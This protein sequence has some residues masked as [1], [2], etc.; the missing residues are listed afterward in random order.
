[1]LACGLAL[2]LAATGCDSAG[3]QAGPGHR[4]QDLALSSQQEAQ[5]GKEAYAELLQKERAHVVRTGPLVDRI[6]TVG[7]NIEK[8]VAIEPLRREINLNVQGYSFAWEYT[9]LDSPQVNAFCLPGGYIA[10]YTGLLRFVRSDDE[11]ATVM[12]H[13]IAHALAHHASE[14]IAR[15]QK[16]ERAMAALGG[17]N[18][19]EMLKLLGIGEAVRELSYD[20]Q[21]ESEA[22]HIGLFLMTFASYDPD[23]AVRFWER[24]KEQSDQHGRTPEILSD[25]PSDARRV[26]QI[27]QWSVR[28]KAALQA[29]QQGHI[30]QP[31]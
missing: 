9:V 29:Y 21:Q 30:A 2:A 4:G 14:R 26:A 25:H 17:Q 16:T 7:H 19:P 15:Q 8:A 28:A 1:M 18:R 13:E 20:R 24:M 27:Q 22:D 12:G 23:Q 3:N 6:R 10:V 31:R 5:L 11:L